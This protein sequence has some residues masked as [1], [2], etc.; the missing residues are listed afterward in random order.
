[1][2]VK[3]RKK[4]LRQAHS[5][6]KNNE[7]LPFSYC[8]RLSWAAYHM[9]LDMLGGNISEFKYYKSN[10]E[11]RFA[12]GTLASQAKSPDRRFENVFL[13]FDAD[14]NLLRSF[15]IENLVIDEKQ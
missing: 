12:S 5:L 4:V 6:R 1:M 14:K 11:I 3:H 9:Y 2:N 8:L 13:Y 10:G 15:K 7:N